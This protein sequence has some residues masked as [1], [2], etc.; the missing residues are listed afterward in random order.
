MIGSLM[1]D[2]PKDIWK[3]SRSKLG[4]TL[5]AVTETMKIF[6]QIVRYKLS[7]WVPS[8]TISPNLTSM[9]VVI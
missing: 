4:T 8:I 9:K 1:N 6:E 2:K 3:H 5:E 7:T